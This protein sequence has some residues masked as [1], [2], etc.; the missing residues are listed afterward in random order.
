[1]DR[2]AAE[3]IGREIGRKAGG[4]QRQRQGVSIGQFQRQDDPSGERTEAVNKP[5]IGA[6]TKALVAELPSGRNALA[7]RAKATPTQAASDRIGAKIPPGTPV[8]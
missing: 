2:P 7:A 6:M 1:M 8:E 5:P 4:E 3:Q